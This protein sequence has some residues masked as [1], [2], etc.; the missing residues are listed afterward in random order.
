MQSAARTF[1]F[2]PPPSLDDIDRQ[3]LV[4]LQNDA[5]ASY[6]EIGRRVHLTQPAVAERIRALE[7]CGAIK[8]YHANVDPSML[9]YPIHAYIAVDSRTLRETTDVLTLVKDMADVIEAHTVT[10]SFGLLLHLVTVSL[11]RLDQII[12]VIAKHSGPTTHIVLRTA[13]DRR[14]IEPITSPSPARSKR[15]QS[16]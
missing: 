11:E 5:R 9:G 6:S 3:I 15:G 2:N 12:H 1:K 8:G 4:I 14:T 10:G 16:R 13:I 7:A